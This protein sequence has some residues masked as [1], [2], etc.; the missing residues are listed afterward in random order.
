[1]VTEIYLIFEG[2]ELRCLYLL[3]QLSRRRSC[4]GYM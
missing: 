2:T 4:H 1:M 3:R